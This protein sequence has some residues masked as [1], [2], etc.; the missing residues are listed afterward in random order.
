[1]ANKSQKGRYQNSDIK[2]KE[3]LATQEQAKYKKGIQ[4]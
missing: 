3:Y 2:K 1:M 4:I